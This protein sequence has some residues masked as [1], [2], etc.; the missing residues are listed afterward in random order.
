MTIFTTHQDITT[1]TTFTNE[2]VFQNIS[3]ATGGAALAITSAPVEINGSTF[4]G[5][6]STTQRSA[7]G[8]AISAKGTAVLTIGTNSLF[9]NGY[10]G[11]AGG[12]IYMAGSAV[13]TVEGATFANNY[14]FGDGSGYNGGAIYNDNRGTGST[15]LS[16]SSST[17]TSNTANGRGGAFDLWGNNYTQNNLVEN[18]IAQNGGAVSLYNAIYQDV[19]STFS[20]NTASGDGGAIALIMNANANATFTNSI[21]TGNKAG[22]SGG[23]IQVKVGRASLDG[24]TFTSNNAS[25]GGAIR[26]ISTI[27]MANSLFQQNTASYGG[28]I[29]T[30]AGNGSGIVT[31]VTDTNFIG[32]TASSG[33]GAYL[34]YF[35]TVNVTGG[36]IQGNSATIGGAVFM[37]ASKATIDGGTYKGNLASDSGGAVYTIQASD[38]SISNAVFTENTAIYGGGIYAGQRNASGIV[39]TITDTDF[40]SNSA[41]SGGAVLSYYAT[42]SIAGGTIS[43]NNATQYGGGV[44]CEYGTNTI[45]GGLYKNNSAHV[46]GGIFN[47]HN[48]TMEITGATITGN[49]ATYTSEGGAGVYNESDS[50]MTLTDVIFE[51]NH[52]NYGAALRNR[53]TSL[54]VTGGTFTENVAIRGAGIWTLFGFE[55]EGSTFSNNVAS[56]GAGLFLSPSGGAMTIRN[57]VFSENVAGDASA[58]FAAAGVYIGSW[59]SDVVSSI[60]NSLFLDNLGTAGRGGALALDSYSTASISGGTFAHNISEAGWGG[61]IYNLGEMAISATLFDANSATA[62]A[63]LGY[64]GAIFNNGILTVNGATFTNNYANA[65][66]GGAAIYNNNGKELAVS[67]TLFDGNTSGTRGGAIAASNTDYTVSGSTFT[68]NQAEDGG[69][70]LSNAN[71]GFT[72][73]DSFFSG[74]TAERGGAVFAGGTISI[75]GSTF[76]TASDT[77]FVFGDVV[78]RGNNLFN[79]DVKGGGLLSIAGG[80]STLTAGISSFETMEIASGAELNLKQDGLVSGTVI[81]NNGQLN[82]ELNSKWTYKTLTVLN[83]VDSFT[84]VDLTINNEAATE[85]ASLNDG[86]QTVSI[87]GGSISIE[88][89]ASYVEAN[90]SL[91]TLVDNTKTNYVKFNQGLSS[92]TLTARTLDRDL[93]FEG[94]GEAETAVNS[95][96]LYAGGN[97]LALKDISWTGSIYG[98]IKDNTVETTELELMNVSLTKDVYGGGVAATTDAGIEGDV[99]AT[100]TNVTGGRSFYGAGYANGG[101]IMV[102]GAVRTTIDGGNYG[103][104]YNGANLS[105]NATGKSYSL[106]GAELTINGGDFSGIVGNGG[107]VRAGQTSLQ[108]ASSLTINGGTFNNYVYGGAFAY[109]TGSKSTTISAGMV[110]VDG[111]IEVTITGGTFH[112]DVFGGSLASNSH[113]ATANTSVTGDIIVTLDASENEIVLNGNVIA[114]SLGKGAVDGDTIVF[115]KGLGSNLTFASDSWV[116]GTSEYGNSIH[117]Y[118]SGVKVLAFNEFT[119]AFTANVGNGAFDRVTVALES[120]V[121]MTNAELDMVSAWNL[122]ADSTISGNLSADTLDLS[123]DALNIKGTLGET[124]AVLLNSVTGLTWDSATTVNLFGETAAASETDGIWESETYRLTAASTGT[125]TVGRI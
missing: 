116:T 84:G 98:G 24:V 121:T 83:G 108:G 20:G 45:N 123:G 25:D 34:G 90:R 117:G 91:D 30:G 44:Y 66:Q 70:A 64:G 106:G 77:I 36:L 21:M 72:V 6:T 1:G 28:A 93:L 57:A 8:G 105:A 114:G 111:D 125:L 80:T 79:A 5:S 55:L 16:V 63:E 73:I 110:D 85:N 37:Q 15:S 86:N 50:L 47:W 22:S 124:D 41:T 32:N 26:N 10:A 115:V 119:G 69:G 2:D 35:G 9:E 107:F 104:I 122:Y 78:L 102:D 96:A 49:T 53:S 82:A 71:G 74:N 31:T 113:I 14:D 99:V 19:G 89:I 13:V 76:A 4:T 120:E 52:A 39:T 109:G 100:L 51:E 17:F 97:S 101:D 40:L 46:G 95:G 48:S 38:V 42:T 92:G 103:A 88:A 29:Y 118:V 60:E 23:A 58:Q 27:T 68:N 94:N 61:A 43:G 75:E 12:V 54:T 67:D 112:A 87:L 56:I 59:C 7:H 65:T 81:T 18:N 33:G 11:G 3:Y 62:A